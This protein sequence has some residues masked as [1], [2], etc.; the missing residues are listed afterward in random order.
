[1]MNQVKWGLSAPRRVAPETNTS[2]AKGE[3]VCIPTLPE[4]TSPSSRS[5]TTRM[6]ARSAS[7]GRKRN[8]IG[9]LPAAKVRKRPLRASSSR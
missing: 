2:S 9:A 1:M 8:P 6:A 4:I 3:E 5:P 7:S